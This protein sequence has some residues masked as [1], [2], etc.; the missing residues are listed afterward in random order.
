MD[1]NYRHPQIKDQGIKIITFLRQRVSVSPEIQ[2]Y[3]LVLD[4]EPKDMYHCLHT[5]FW[6]FINPHLTSPSGPIRYSILR[7]AF[8][9]VFFVF[10]YFF[11]SITVE[12][13]LQRTFFSSNMALHWFTPQDIPVSETKAGLAQCSD[14][15]HHLFIL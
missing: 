8:E 5:I 13:S 1:G 12:V 3:S 7:S 9:Q 14:A 6:K 11:F 4:P 15:E 2:W 10:R